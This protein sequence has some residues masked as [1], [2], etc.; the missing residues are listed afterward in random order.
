MRFESPRT[1]AMLV[2]SG[3]TMNVGGVAVAAAG[4]VVVLAVFL[5]ALSDP[6]Y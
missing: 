1:L 2:P 5:H 4:A 6:N 3:D